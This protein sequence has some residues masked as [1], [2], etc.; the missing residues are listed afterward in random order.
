MGDEV[1]VLSLTQ[2]WA[3][4]VRDLK[5]QW[6]TRSWSTNYRGQLAIHAAKGFPGWSKEFAEANGYAAF[7]L[8]P[9]G[10]IIC[11]CDLTDCQPTEIIRTKLSEQELKWGDYTDGRFAFR[12]ENIQP[13]QQPILASGSLGLWMTSLELHS[14]IAAQ[15]PVRI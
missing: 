6:E 12:L 13:L 15:V 2:P 11:V 4:A 1:R 5:K 10:K 3:Q 14:A 8:L 9:V 7:G